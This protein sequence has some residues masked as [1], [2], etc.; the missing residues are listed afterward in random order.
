MDNYNNL[1]YLF[2]LLAVS[3]AEYL[4]PQRYESKIDP[5]GW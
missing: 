2:S 1:L 5:K 4:L 3:E